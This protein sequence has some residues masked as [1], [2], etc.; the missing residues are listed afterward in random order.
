MDEARAR[1]ACWFPYATS[2]Q[3]AQAGTAEALDQA[4]EEADEA[5]RLRIAPG[6]AGREAYLKALLSEYGLSEEELAG[7]GLADLET[8]LV[9]QE[10]PVK[11]DQSP[12]KKGKDKVKGSAKESRRGK[13]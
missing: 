9:E 1:L 2:R 10:Q 11:N 6:G 12:G 5:E 4:V 3:L 8:L 7:M 13:G